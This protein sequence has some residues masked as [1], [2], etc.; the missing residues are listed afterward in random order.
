MRKLK[1]NVGEEGVQRLLIR[2]IEKVALFATVVLVA[3]F[4]CMGYSL[5]RLPA[6]KSPVALLKRVKQVESHIGADNW[7]LLAILRTPDLRHV[8]RVEEGRK[9]TSERA[10][11]IAPLD[12]PSIRPKTPRS[13]PRV[14]API[15]LEVTSGWVPLAYVPKR[16]ESD[17]LLEQPIAKLKEESKARPRR[18]YKSK[19]KPRGH[20]LLSSDDL[21]GHAESDQS[22]SIED[23]QRVLTDYQKAVLGGFQPS[24]EAIAKSRFLVA[25]KAVVPFELQWQAFEELQNSSGFDAERDVPIYRWFRVER[26]EV[27]DDQAVALNWIQIRTRAR[28]LAYRGKVGGWT[29][30]P[31]EL[32]DPESVDTVLTLSLPPVLAGS[33]RPWALHSAIQNRQAKLLLDEP[34]DPGIGPTDDRPDGPP[35]PGGGASAGQNDRK[36]AFVGNFGRVGFGGAGA[37][38]G[39]D[40]AVSQPPAKYKMIRFYDTTAKPGKAYRYR[41]KVQLFDPNRPFDAKRDPSIETLA[42]A[43]QARINQ[44]AATEGASR[45]TFWVESEW[46]QPS[47][48]VNVQF[49]PPTLLASHVTPPRETVLPAQGAVKPR[50]AATEP[51]ATVVASIWDNTL[52]AE[53]PTELSTIRGGMLDASQAVDVLHPITRQFHTLDN[54]QFRS[55]AMLLDMRGGEPLSGPNGSRADRSVG[56]YSPGEILILD[57]SGNLQVGNEFDDEEERRKE[58]F[59]NDVPSATDEGYSGY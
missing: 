7:A 17:V 58:L 26:A 57:E 37:E 42:P 11:R 8:E 5:D 6:D 52:A 19:R 38:F 10:Y 12:S 51:R 36:R 49:R 55:G 45:K 21:Q 43:V 24:G 4:F 27:H 56:F 29:E 1:F 9:R 41:L 39:D 47:A 16:G 3:V 59:L 31:D 34:A 46:S 23:E 18:T 32:A 14:Y 15:K 30:G 50:F 2:H 54:Y 53:V 40:A 44:L 13:D 35:M 28:G 20:D 22:L 25:I 33:L 48:I